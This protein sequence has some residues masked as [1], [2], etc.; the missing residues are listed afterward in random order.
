M[1]Y[2]EFIRESTPDTEHAIELWYEREA[3]RLDRRYTRGAMTAAEYDKA[4]RSL[5]LQCELIYEALGF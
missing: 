1:D 5:T 4:C 2:A 3:D